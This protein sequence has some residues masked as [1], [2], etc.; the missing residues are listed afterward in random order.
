MHYVPA[1]D[2]LRLVCCL[3][4]VVGH[5]AWGT[6][7]GRVASFGVDVFFSLSGYLIT[8]LLLRERSRRGRVDLRSFYMRRALRIFPAYYASLAAAVLL[9]WIAAA[10][11]TR[12]FHG[13]SDA[14][15]FTTTLAS[16]V[17]FIGNW[18][19]A[20]VPSSLAVLWSVC[21]EEQFYVLFPPTFATSQRNFPVVVPALAGLAIAWGVRILLAARHDGDLYRNTFA[22]ADGLLLG[23]LLAQA[24]AGDAPRLRAWVG[25]HAGVLELVACGASVFALAFRGN[26]SPLSY[27]A[28]FLASAICATTIVAAMALGQGPIARVLARKPLARGGTLTFAGYLVHMYGVTAAFGIT[29][30]IALGA[31]ETPLRIAIAI[32]TTFALAYVAHVA[33]ERPFLRLK[34]KLGSEDVMPREP[35]FSAPAAAPR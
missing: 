6:I 15:F 33:V 9:T 1:L 14:R 32:V 8:S 25:G 22:H 29:R 12:S 31:G 21:I 26:G 10:P 27:W 3:A 30:R 35:A 11:F 13:P 2:G 23:A 7:A 28:S 16:Y 19:D 34:A 17:A 4:V 18:F 20:P 5:A 24:T